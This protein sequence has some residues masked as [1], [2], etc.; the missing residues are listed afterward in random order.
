[1]TAIFSEHVVEEKDRFRGVSACPAGWRP[2]SF[3]SLHHGSYNRIFLQ[4]M[5]LLFAGVPYFPASVQM[6]SQSTLK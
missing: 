3:S 1:M 6:P 4:T 2:W 5:Q